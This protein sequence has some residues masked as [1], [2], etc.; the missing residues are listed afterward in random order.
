MIKFK[1][2]QIILTHLENFNPDDKEDIIKAEKILRAQNKIDVSIILND[3]D[4]A[5]Q[6]FYE[7]GSQFMPLLKD[8][9]IKAILKNEVNEFNGFPCSFIT[10]E[11]HSITTIFGKL[12]ADDI[13]GFIS[14]C[15]KENAFFKINDLF[16]SYKD[17]ISFEVIEKVK[18]K[19][20]SLNNTLIDILKDP[21]KHYYLYTQDNFSYTINP[22]YYEIQ[23]RIDSFYFEKDILKITNLI[24]EKQNTNQ[25][26]RIAMNKVIIALAGF[27][28]ENSII[29][30]LLESNKG[31]AQSS[32]DLQ[33]GRT[34]NDSSYL[35]YFIIVLVVI[36][37]VVFL[38]AS[39][40]ISGSALRI[41]ILPILLIARLFSFFNKK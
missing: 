19:I 10:E 2:L 12:F 39:S 28:S 8:K 7:Y 9:N 41:V 14:K 37:F 33:E 40:G 3:V 34:S 35:V 20:S 22:S 1:L 24:V 4:N 36:G 29:V 25:S 30:K 16:Q 32:I 17:I 27:V 18:V 21:T 38:I 26:K 11:N 31:K 6:F 15:L 23:S 5:I 13:Y